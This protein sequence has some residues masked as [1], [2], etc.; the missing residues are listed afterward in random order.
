MF[1]MPSVTEVGVSLY[2]AKRKRVLTYEDGL[3]AVQNVVLGDLILFIEGLHPD[4]KAIP[5]VGGC[6]WTKSFDSS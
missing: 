1:G 5:Q 3:D 6:I 4:F 2:T